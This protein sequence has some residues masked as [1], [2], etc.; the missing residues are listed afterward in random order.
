MHACKSLVNSGVVLM[1][2]HNGWKIIQ[3][4]IPWYD[5]YGKYDEV[6]I[7]NSHQIWIFSSDLMKNTLQNSTFV[8]FH[9][10]S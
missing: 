6:F 10:T 8:K 7:T 5:E 9:I 3:P 4:H 2:D 1:R